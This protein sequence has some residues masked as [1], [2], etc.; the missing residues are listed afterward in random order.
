MELPPWRM[1][2]PPI[3]PPVGCRCVSC[4]TTPRVKKGGAVKA[5]KAA[6]ASQHET[7]KWKLVHD[8]LARLVLQ[9]RYNEAMEWALEWISNGEKG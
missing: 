6:K 2:Q 4:R 7:G 3:P 9:R 5:V 8:E 1:P